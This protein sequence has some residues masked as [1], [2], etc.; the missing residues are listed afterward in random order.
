[1][2]DTML[3]AELHLVKI[4]GQGTFGTVHKAIWRGSLVAAKV[5]NIPA[6]SVGTVKGEIQAIG[7][8]YYFMCGSPV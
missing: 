5:I 2:T 7:Y 8:V 3:L 6:G 1:M 4:I